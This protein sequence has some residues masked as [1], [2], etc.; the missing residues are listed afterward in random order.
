[1][2]VRFLS[3]QPTEWRPLKTGSKHPEKVNKVEQIPK[4]DT[5]WPKTIFS[6]AYPDTPSYNNVR[7]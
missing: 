3:K 1:M 4:Q 6:A 7:K 2:D 5:F